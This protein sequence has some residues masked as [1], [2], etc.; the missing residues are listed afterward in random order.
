MNSYRGG[1]ALAL[2][3]KIEL[4]NSTFMWNSSKINF[5]T[6]CPLFIEPVTYAER[7]RHYFTAN[8]MTDVAKKRSILLTVCGV[9][10]YKLLCSLVADGEL[11]T[12]D[13]IQRPE[14]W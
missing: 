13:F 3:I 10:T 2:S 11:D 1:S 6:K 4:K 14:T 7:L 9:P 8:D 5:R 12:M